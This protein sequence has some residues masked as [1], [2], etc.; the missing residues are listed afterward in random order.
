MIELTA[1]HHLAVF[2]SIYVPTFL[3][4]VATLVAFKKI[5]INQPRKPESK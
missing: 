1:I 2:L 5:T 4:A 3:V